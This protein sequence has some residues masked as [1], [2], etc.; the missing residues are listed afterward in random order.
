M[1]SKRKLDAL[2]R[3]HAEF[4]VLLNLAEL[5]DGE[6]TRQ[7][8]VLGGALVGFMPALIDEIERLSREP[9]HTVVPKWDIRGGHA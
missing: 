7:V 9:E 5:G 6:A 4:L 2:R 1:I 3:M 8:A